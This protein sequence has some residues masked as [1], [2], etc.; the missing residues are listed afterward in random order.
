MESCAEVWG[1]MGVLC[2]FVGAVLLPSGRYFATPG[3]AWSPA[4][5]VFAASGPVM[6]AIRIAPPYPTAGGNGLGV[7]GMRG[8]YIHW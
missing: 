2:E 1:L 3:G 4:K 7:E 8:I 5:V 6:S